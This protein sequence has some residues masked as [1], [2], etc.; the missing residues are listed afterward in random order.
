[1]ADDGKIYIYISNKAPGGTN[2]PGGTDDTD[3][4]KSKKNKILDNAITHELYH[5]VK[6]QLIQDINFRANHI[7][8]F[9][10][11]YQSQ[12]DTQASLRVATNVMGI[13]GCGI[14]V[15]K[16]ALAANPVGAVA[17]GLLAVTS[18]VSQSINF[19]RQEK[20]NLLNNKKTNYEIEQL[21]IRSGL[22]VLMDGS[23]GTLD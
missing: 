8:D 19:N 18:L 12:R 1:M 22:N 6:S 14:A 23:R 9:T 17:A 15:A 7:G 2:T 13:V 10:G 16:Y 4:N 20:V 3:G 5:L 11:N 21:R